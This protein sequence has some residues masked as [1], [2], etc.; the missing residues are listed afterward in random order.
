MTDRLDLLKIAQEEQSDDLFKNLDSILKRSSIQPKGYPDAIIWEGGNP[1]GGVKPVAHALTDTFALNGTLM[2]L[3]VLGLPFLGVPMMAQFRHDTK[4]ISLDLAGDRSS[5]AVTSVLTSHVVPR[6]VLPDAGHGTIKNGKATCLCCGRT[7][8]G[9]RVKAQLAQHAGGTDAGSRCDISHAD[10]ASLLAVVRKYAPGIRFCY[11]NELKKKPGLG[12]KLVVAITVA[13]AGNVTEAVIV[14]DTLGSAAL[15][16]C[17]IAQIVA[18][19]F[20]AISQGVVTF[21]APFVFTPPE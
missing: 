10:G 21:R 13:A 14:Q 3:D 1:A 5:K 6:R 8:S 12:G 17:A 7:M 15:T 4:L 2:A 11:E 9:A 19:R 16:Q 20:P 18:W